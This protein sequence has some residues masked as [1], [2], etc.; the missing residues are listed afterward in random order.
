MTTKELEI[1]M[2]ELGILRS[3]FCENIVE[4]IEIFEDQDNMHIV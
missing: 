2:T 4:I 1:H 3:C